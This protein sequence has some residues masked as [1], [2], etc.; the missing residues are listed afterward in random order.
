LIDAAAG[1]PVGYV[2]L[3]VGSGPERERLEAQVGERGL[4]GR[5]IFAG[6]VPHAD[7]PA[8]LDAM[9]VAVAPFAPMNGFYFSPLK[10]NEY[11]AAELPVVASRQGDIPKLLGSS[12]LLVEPGDASALRA[13]LLRLG[14]D[15]ELRARLGDAGRAHVASRSW[16]AVAAVVER[17]LAR[18]PLEP[19]RA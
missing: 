19:V 6:A 4:G 9:D 8:Y 5:V 13:A 2:L 7:I 1:L 11:M 12:G 15:A 10:V 14:E 3:V 18:Q 16:T 17:L